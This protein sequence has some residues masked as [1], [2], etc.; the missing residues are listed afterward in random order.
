VWIRPVQR[1]AHLCR[2]PRNTSLTT[3]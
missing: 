2:G 3:E 1:S